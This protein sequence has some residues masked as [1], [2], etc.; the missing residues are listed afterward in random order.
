LNLPHY[1]HCH[2]VRY[3]YPAP[4]SETPPPDYSTH[5]RQPASPAFIQL[6]D[7]AGCI[8]AID[9]I[10]GIYTSIGRVTE[11]HRKAYPNLRTI[12][13]IAHIL[14]IELIGGGGREY[15]YSSK[16]RRDS[17]LRSISLALAPVIVSDPNLDIDLLRATIAG[18]PEHE[19]NPVPEVGE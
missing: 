19:G 8:L 1:L 13:D 18:A 2:T 7:E 17:A 3:S 9:Q 14:T 5:L 12:T 15:I 10:A 4:M 11:A 16:E 6:G